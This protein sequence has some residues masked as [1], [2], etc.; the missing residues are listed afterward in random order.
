MKNIARV[1][2]TD[3]AKTLLQQQKYAHLLRQEGDGIL[4]D[5]RFADCGFE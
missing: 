5:C 4:L 3:E 2:V 1:K